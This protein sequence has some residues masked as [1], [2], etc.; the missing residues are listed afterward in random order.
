MEDT[1]HRKC[2]NHR[3]LNN[4]TQLLPHMQQSSVCCGGSQR[5]LFEL[6]T[7]LTS[8][9]LRVTDIVMHRHTFLIHMIH[10]RYIYIFTKQ[11]ALF[12]DHYN[13]EDCPCI[14]NRLSIN[15]S[16]WLDKNIVRQFTKMSIWTSSKNGL[17][18]TEKSVIDDYTC[19]INIDNSIRCHIVTANS[20]VCIK[21]LV[22]DTALS[23]GH[24]IQLD[25]LHR[26]TIPN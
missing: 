24:E 11:V 7:L 18:R 19:I 22:Y 17:L 21:N 9:Q 3:P 6:Y 20:V 16:S 12:K 4:I 25:Q 5:K 14:R 8:T 26:I 2:N 10:I 1:E 23:S 15:D 13:Q